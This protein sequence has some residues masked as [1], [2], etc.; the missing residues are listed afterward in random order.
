[1]DNDHFLRDRDDDEDVDVSNSA[2]FEYSDDEQEE[3]LRPSSRSGRE[4][5]SKY[6]MKGVS[7][8]ARLT[9]FDP[10]QEQ[11]KKNSSSKKSRSKASSKK[12]SKAKR[13]T[14]KSSSGDSQKS[15]D[16]QSRSDPYHPNELSWMTRMAYSFR[17]PVIGKSHKNQGDGEKKEVEQR[18]AAVA[19][20]DFEHRRHR[21]TGSGATEE[22]PHFNSTGQ[23]RH[24]SGS[25]N[26]MLPPPPPHD[27][28]HPYHNVLVPPSHQSSEASPLLGA[29][30]TTPPQVERNKSFGS[31]SSQRIGA[32][33]HDR[34]SAVVAAAFLQDYETNRPPTFGSANLADIG[35]HQVTL[36]HW[37][38]SFL[39]N[40]CRVLATLGIFLSSFLEGCL[41]C[42]SEVRNDAF[43]AQRYTLTGLN[44][45]AIVVFAAD[46]A[47]HRALRRGTPAVF[48]QSTIVALI[49]GQ[50]KPPQTFEERQKSKASMERMEKHEVRV[51]R[52]E[53]FIYPLILFCLVLGLENIS[54]FL[55]VP[56]DTIVLY[57]S[58][59]KPLVLFYVSSQARDAAAA[60]GRILKIVLRVLVMEM[61]L[62]LMFAA[63]ACRLFHNFASFASLDVAWLSLFELSTTVV[64]PSIW[65]P[66]YDARKLSALFFVIFIVTSVFYLHSLVLSVVFQ[67]YIQAAAEIHQRNATDRE[68]SVHLAFMALLQDEHHE[69][70]HELGS[71]ESLVDVELVRDTLRI[72]RPHYNTLKINALV[73]ILDPSSQGTVDYV[74]FRTKIRQALNA[75]I[76]TARNAS[77]LAMSVELIAVLVAISNFVYVMLVSSPFSADWFDSIQEE[78]GG[79]I[80][81]LAA[82]EL[83]IRFNPLRIPDFTPLTRLNA[84]FDGTALFAALVSCTGIALFVCGRPMALEFILV[85]RS[86][87]IIR[88][89][90]F[91]Q[92][93][94]DIVRRT[95]DVIPALGGPVILVIST[96]HIFVY[97]G[98]ALWGGAVEV[99]AQEGE[100]E[101]LYDLNNFNSYHEGAVT[102]FQVLVVNDWHAIA[103]VFLY[104]TRCADA[105][106]V[107]PFFISAN[108]IGVSIML[109]VLTA[110][111]VEG[112]VTKLN[113]DKDAPAEATATMHKEKELIIDSSERPGKRVS[114]TS[115][116]LTKSS[117]SAPYTRD[118]QDDASD[119][120]SPSEMF[121]FDVYEREG[122]DKI[123]QTVAGVSQYE[124]DIARQVCH[125][126]EVFESLSPD[127]ETVG[128]LVCDQQTLERFGNRRFKTKAIG[129]LSESKLHETVTE[130]HTELLALAPRTGLQ[131]QDRSLVR[132]F[133]HRR[134]PGKTL[135]ISASLLR[136]NP[137]LSLFVD[138]TTVS[139]PGSAYASGTPPLPMQDSR[140]A[141][142]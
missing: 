10:M 60:V 127:R 78:I 124:A 106:I 84:T 22:Y 131:A 87:D 94:R 113:N 82:F 69:S 6:R 116:S 83:L 61:L 52:A 66:I 43:Y 35:E 53:K 68:D 96:V 25:L 1:M 65:M 7:E 3:P 101:E 37:K 103:E 30:F 59:S 51:S 105:L 125:Y 108:L 119:A 112:F 38:H 44:M 14:A 107:Y 140:K 135:E 75:S 13:K 85:G 18:Q 117:R 16:S 64:N 50:T 126:L 137:A 90:R 29:G 67:T 71:N 32:P 92:I 132:T 8:S 141:H 2:F 33:D 76:R 45:F 142:A 39:M 104:A 9:T 12:D 46:I 19:T 42:E 11:P 114:T 138:K 97:L 34:L 89:L 57:S 95:S 130:M 15:S 41:T 26:G 24:S 111:F 56:N 73:E 55:L 99:G 102:M 79:F 27:P 80:T 62:I 36:F 58:I 123:M 133:P 109:N 63:V 134:D 120:S 23:H 100:I 4:A 115:K 128:Y 91:F 110:F 21:R 77:N 98:M 54:R 48:S 122:F 70:S 72:M 136:R 40:L 47:M 139:K 81:L 121:E 86:I 88:A 49:T 5:R 31:H 74:T 17:S 20:S 118:D 28:W 93:F 129:F